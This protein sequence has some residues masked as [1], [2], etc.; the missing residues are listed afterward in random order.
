[1]SLSLLADA[2]VV[3]HL[4]FVLFAVAGGLLALRWRWMPWVHLPALGWAALVEFSGRTCPLTPL[5]QRLR[6]L[7]GEGR[8]SGGFIEHYLLPLLYPHGLTPEL[9]WLLGA[10]LIVVNLAAYWLV[11]RTRP[12]RR[13]LR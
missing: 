11:W 6:A 12:R 5:E 8:Y 3:L 13:P 10:G 4:A 9:Q 7:A 2:V 1:M